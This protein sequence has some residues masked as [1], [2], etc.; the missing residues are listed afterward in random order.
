MFASQEPYV[1]TPGNYAVGH[2]DWFPT[3]PECPN[4]KVGVP[5]SS[6]FADPNPSGQ[7]S[8]A[9]C[10]L[11]STIVQSMNLSCGH[12]HA[13]SNCAICYSQNTDHS[14]TSA[15]TGLSP[16]PFSNQGSPETDSSSP[17]FRQSSPH[18]P[19]HHYETRS[20]VN[21]NMQTPFHHDMRQ[22]RPSLVAEQQTLYP[23]PPSLS[24][25]YSNPSSRTQTPVAGMQPELQQLP[26]HQVH[27]Y[28]L[29]IPKESIIIKSNSSSHSIQVTELSPA[30]IAD[31]SFSTVSNNS[32]PECAIAK[33]NQSAIQKQ[34]KR[35]KIDAPVRF[36][37][38]QPN[39]NKL[40]ICFGTLFGYKTGTDY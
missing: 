30:Q 6:A 16:Q 31:Q 7:V 21:N 9:E 11:H 26:T 13:C 10:F 38:L 40:F 8:C 17:V 19:L 24:H 25:S 37:V 36:I 3:N 28:N 14:A 2:E 12:L 5:F 4:H 27:P 39:A 1:L 33:S 23:A 35:M 34:Q 32:S 29:T 22:R 18:I 20:N 15:S